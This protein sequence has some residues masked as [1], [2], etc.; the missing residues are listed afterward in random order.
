MAKKKRV[1]IADE[2]PI[3]SD[4]MLL[5][6][7]REYVRRAAR[8]VALRWGFSAVSEQI[9]EEI[10]LESGETITQN[11]TAGQILHQIAAQCNVSLEDMGINSHSISEQPRPQ[12]PVI[13]FA[14][15]DFE[16]EYMQNPHPSDNHEPFNPIAAEY[17]NFPLPT[18][19]RPEVS[20]IDIVNFESS[21]RC[22]SEIP[23]GTIGS[24]MFRNGT[25]I[26]ARASPEQ[27]IHVGDIVTM[28][29]EDGS[30]QEASPED[31]EEI[32]GVVGYPDDIIQNVGY[33]QNEQ[34]P[35]IR[36]GHLSVPR[37]T[38]EQREQL[39]LYHEFIERTLWRGCG[40]Q[41]HQNGAHFTGAITDDVAPY[42]PAIRPETDQ[43]KF[44]RYTKE[45]PHKCVK[46]KKTILFS[47]A[48]NESKKKGF[49]LKKFKKLWKSKYVEFYCC[50]CFPKPKMNIINTPHPNVGRDFFDSIS[51]ALRS[52]QSRSFNPPWTIV[53]RVEAYPPPQIS[54]DFGEFDDTI[55]YFIY[56]TY[57]V[58]FHIEVFNIIDPTIRCEINR[59]MEVPREL[60]RVL[61]IREGTGIRDLTRMRTYAQSLLNK[62]HQ[63]F[64]CYH[65]FSYRDANIC[66]GC[67]ISRE[68]L[69]L[70]N[71]KCG[72]DFEYPIFIN[73]EHEH[74]FNQT[75]FC[76]YCHRSAAS[77]NHNG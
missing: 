52:L 2:I 37:L 31:I 55:H 17:D 11:L 45:Y 9:T 24:I 50:Y 56:R 47:H 68:T 5:A 4:I 59:I 44:T 32:I 62:F 23:A 65:T 27:D 36:L 19:R 73:R 43:Q 49:D 63:S 22:L 28:C 7:I 42:N 10:E 29:E 66:E 71:H 64:A 13:S 39:R 1:L 72:P 41:E 3:C 70:V 6:R 25:Q 57:R 61:S 38:E 18:V 60:G 48:F 67:G 16:R 51:S 46:C 40:Q 14:R 35:M 15:W 21:G 69:D 30:V 34:V 58:V 53:H 54:E 33:H 20:E 75:G 74:I 77:I 76:V 12:E 8:V 26:W